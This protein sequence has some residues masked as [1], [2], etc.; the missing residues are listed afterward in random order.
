MRR[1]LLQ[2]LPP[3]LEYLLSS[4]DT[5]STVRLT[6]ATLLSSLRHVWNSSAF[7][8]MLHSL[9]AH[10]DLLKAMDVAEL[11]G[12]M[13]QVALSFESV[14][15]AHA[16]ALAD[17]VVSQELTCPVCLERKKDTAFGC[18]HQTCAECARQLRDCCICRRRIGLMLRVY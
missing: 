13:E 11:E 4:A 1:W 9:R 5:V 14:R 10:P 17:V 8:Q 18:G 6:A 12:L 7:V 15:G 3:P 2:A 16:Q